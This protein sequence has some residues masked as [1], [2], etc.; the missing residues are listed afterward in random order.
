M[1]RFSNYFLVAIVLI[2]ASCTQPMDP[3]V[4][5]VIE[6]KSILQ[7]NTWIL[8]DYTIKLKNPD[9]PPPMLI[10]DGDSSIE[11]GNYHLPNSLPTGSNFPQFIMQFS[12]DNKILVDS[13]YTNNFVG[14]GG[15]YFV[16]NQTD[17]KLKP[18]KVEK[19]I[20]KYF[21]SPDDK[22]M[23]F[24]LT[25]EQAS[26]AIQKANQRL[27]DDAVNGRPDKIG[28]GI[29]NALHNNPKIK[30]AIKKW[31]EHGLAGKLPGIFDNQ[32]EHNTQQT[33]ELLRAHLLDSINWKNVLKEA[34]QH[35]LHKIH[36]KDSAVLAPLVVGEIADQIGEEFGI[37]PV[38][39]IIFPYMATRENGNP[40]SEAE[41]IAT[42]IV[43]LLG[44]IFSEQNLEKI[45]EPIWKKF[46]EL[47]SALIDT[48][49][50][51]L[52]M[53]VQ[54][55]WL[56]VDTLS[57]V[58]LPITQKIDATPFSKLN[59]LAQEATD[60]LEV[61]VDKLNN[62]FP[63]LGL[64]P[65]YNSIEST[66]DAILKAAKP[67]IG[68]QG[69]QKVA[70][71][72]AQVL[73]DEVFTTKN[74]ENAFVAALDYLQTIDP[75]TAAEA[76]AK[77]LVSLENKIGPELI[78]WLTEKLGPILDGDAAYKI[79]NKV[80]DFSIANMGFGTIKDLVLP[81]FEK[82]LAVNGKAL[83]KHIAEALINKKL[84]KEGVDAEELGD[85]IFE[86]LHDDGSGSS[87]GDR[88]KQAMADHDLTGGGEI[89]DI[90]GKIIS[91]ILYAE[92]WEAFKIANNFEEATIVIQHE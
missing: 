47:D 30:A 64:D 2:T 32:I 43:K 66:I 89:P 74:I 7:S 69:P 36:M 31:L 67:V 17:I 57:Q 75:E 27:I 49:A 24:S 82:T 79:G 42:L 92:A 22:T 39:D 8:T 12:T 87:L 58:F 19:L 9:I 1:R 78:A 5:S 20:Y 85:V 84:A 76:I 63:N 65:D 4:E 77:W 55:N 23:T 38:Y 40:E 33:S 10:N 59:E 60:S 11:A 61:F 81:E 46:T 91:F 70:D 50:V 28:D 80:H 90:I 3:V 86:A 54:D 25:A 72:I 29:A 88:I 41:K 34:I 35:E 13:A 48:I 6:T 45:I 68:I 26:D 15:K 62:R 83:A 18:S 51:Q 52:T 73:I 16:F 44:D 21:Y 71:E 14:L 56:N 53:I 37:D